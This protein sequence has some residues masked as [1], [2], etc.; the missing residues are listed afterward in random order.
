MKPYEVLREELRNRGYSAQ[1]VAGW[2]N[3]SPACASA[4]MT[5]RTIWSI[6]EIYVVM[7]KLGL[8]YRE[9]YHVFP[10]RG[11]YTGPVG[12]HAVD[13][14]THALMT[15]LI[16]RLGGPGP[17][18]AGPA[19][20]DAGSDGGHGG[21]RRGRGGAA[22]HEGQ[23]KGEEAAQWPAETTSPSALS[24]TGS[25]PRTRAAARVPGP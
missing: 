20:A 9:I 15:L 24:A 1:D 8:D 5:G 10:P 13:P 23:A 3:L 22:V 14:T 7:D 25:T 4:R 2:L 19:G 11:A 6:E 17:G 18:R 12:A 16:E 21:D